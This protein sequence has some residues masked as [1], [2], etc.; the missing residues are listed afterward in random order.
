MLVGVGCYAVQIA[1]RQCGNMSNAFRAMA[2]IVQF[3]KAR[4]STRKDFQSY[5]EGSRDLSV[6]N[7]DRQDLSSEYIVDWGHDLAAWAW[8]S[9]SARADSERF[10]VDAPTSTWGAPSGSTTAVTARTEVLSTTVGSIFRCDRVGLVLGG[11]PGYLTSCDMLI[12]F[13]HVSLGARC[14][15]RLYVTPVR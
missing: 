7:Y 14:Q 4:P 8:S 2:G 12:L 10:D 9:A 15:S 1:A 5:C 11:I 13:A 6:R 3:V